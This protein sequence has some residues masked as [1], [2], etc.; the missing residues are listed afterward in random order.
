MPEILGLNGQKDG[1]TPEPTPKRP[2]LFSRLKSGYKRRGKDVGLAGQG[3]EEPSSAHL[4]ET[5][6]GDEEL[7]LNLPES[8]PRGELD[9]G[10]L[11]REFLDVRRDPDLGRIEL[12]EPVPEVEP[13][14]PDLKYPE[15]GY[16]SFE[17]VRGEAGEIS[18]LAPGERTPLGRFAVPEFDPGILDQPEATAEAGSE[19]V[20]TFEEP[21]VLDAAV[22]A[23]APNMPDAEKQT[24]LGELRT[25]RGKKELARKFLDV[26]RHTT[27]LARGFLV[28]AGTGAVVR[29]GLRE[30]FGGG[31]GM[32]IAIGAAAGAAAEGAKAYL[33]ERR[34]V[35]VKDILRQ[36]AETNDPIQGAAMLVK[37]KQAY[38]E[39]RISGNP[40]DVTWLAN[41]LR[42][43]ELIQKLAVEE[44]KDETEKDKLLRIFALADETRRDRPATTDRETLDLLKKINFERGPVDRARV[45]KAMLRGAVTGAIGGAVGAAAAEW[46]ADHISPGSHAATEAVSYASRASD[47]A[48]VAEEAT[49]RATVRQV[50]I[51]AKITRETFAEANRDLPAKTFAVAAEKGE[52]FTHLARKA[53]H[54]YLTN[55]AKLSG[56]SADIPPERLVYAEDYLQRKIASAAEH[57]PVLG[58]NFRISGGE[59]AEA[60]ARSQNLEGA[61]LKNLTELVSAPGHRL[62]SETLKAMTDFADPAGE[63]NRFYE[64]AARQAEAAFREA[65]NE[66]AQE[67]A[68][69]AKQEA[70]AQAAAALATDLAAKEALIRR[71]AIGS[72]VALGA[73]SSIGASIWLHRRKGKSAA[74][75][76]ETGEANEEAISLPPRPK[77][78][79]EP[80]SDLRSLIAAYPDIRIAASL[81]WQRLPEEQRRTAVRNLDE[82]LTEL[83]P[84]NYA[85]QEI[86]LSEYGSRLK[87]NG[88]FQL[89]SSLSKDNL[90]KFLSER[91][92]VAKDRR[93]KILEA[94]TQLREIQDFFPGLAIG[95]SDLL[96]GEEL[97]VRLPV[98]ART[99]RG[100]GTERLNGKKLFL[101]VSMTPDRRLYATNDGVLMV[102]PSAPDKDIKAFLESNA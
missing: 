30:T 91:L 73:A 36:L 48:V 6:S 21:G 31:F 43:I 95:R 42:E 61:G 100:I 41:E 51:G 54:D 16:P 2:G 58:E 62:S 15:A 23:A 33:A 66:L 77:A 25:E 57:A 97:L 37:A 102:D 27:A 71:I 11:N 56:L 59:I 38:A 5:R 93:E 94:D 34:K 75:A 14:I 29:L 89:D 79:R 98:L 7:D 70:E 69:A 44:A 47:T 8:A 46:I 83:N 92:P 26:L 32:G 67:L 40:Q 45:A 35:D 86:Y 4:P 9:P 50:E 18:G 3:A 28:G 53:I 63:A 74:L 88:A 85:E 78:E 101:H 80:A 1:K 22:S 12:P 99:L 64:E 72:A 13:R 39:A 84:E 20:R 90:R 87:D 81:G 17:V 49:A 55:Q 96:S 24:V 19:A 82:V 65:K 68:A 52:G 10:D 76:E 60:V